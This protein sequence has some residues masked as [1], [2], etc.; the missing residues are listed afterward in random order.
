M[1]DVNAYAD[2]VT[3]RGIASAAAET[4][5]A[6]HAMQRAGGVKQQVYGSDATRAL[7]DL[8]AA[9]DDLAAAVE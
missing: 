2:E 6:W 3:W 4:V 8:C 9:M 7:E 5:A 1:P